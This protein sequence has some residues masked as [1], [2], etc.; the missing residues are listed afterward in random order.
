MENVKFYAKE[1]MEFICATAKTEAEKSLY[2]KCIDTHLERLESTYDKPVHVLSIDDI[3]TWIATYPLK[4]LSTLC[5]LCI[6]KKYLD[7]LSINEVLS[8]YLG[9]LKKEDIQNL[10]TN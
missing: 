9:Q 6:V 4:T 1:K 8:H 2:T 3:N 5:I 10:K 7:F